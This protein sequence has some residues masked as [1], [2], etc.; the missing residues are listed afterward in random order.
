M[1]WFLFRACVCF[2]LAPRGSGHCT[3]SACACTVPGAAAAPGA[4]SA[5]PG[6]SICLH[7]ATADA[8]A[9]SPVGTSMGAAA[10]HWRTA[11]WAPHRAVYL[12]SRGRKQKQRK[13]KE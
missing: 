3:C 9:A 7:S 1:V 8:K 4:Q 13:N 2:R 12:R 11:D 6:M 5:H 10:S